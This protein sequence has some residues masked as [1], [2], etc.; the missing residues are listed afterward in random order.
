MAT[1]TQNQIA[2]PDDQLQTTNPLGV[3]GGLVNSPPSATVPPAPPAPTYT[4]TPTTATGYTATPYTVPNEAT[5]QERVKSIIGEDSALMQQ[6]ETRARQEAQ[7]RGLV[8]SSL[9]VGA[10][11]QAVI[12]QALPIAQQDAQTYANAATNTANQQNAAS[13]FNAGAQNTVGLANAQQQNA[14]LANNQQAAVQLTNTQMQREAQ[15]ALANLDTQTR[16]ALSTMDTQ[17]RQ[18]LQTNQSASNAY[19]QAVTNISNITNSNTMS[20]EAKDRAV[21]TQLNLLNEQL[22]TIGTLASTSPAEISELN[23]GSF[24]QASVETAGNAPTGTSPNVPS[25]SPGNLPPTPSAPTSVT[26]QGTPYWIGANGQTFFN[27]LA[28]QESLSG[29]SLPGY[30]GGQLQPSGYV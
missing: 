1:T 12:A 6:A 15:I 24:F 21:Q 13:Q 2:P 23:L 22:R 7:A 5:V 11:Q 25:V 19:V 28:A 30:I 14:A 17:T 26:P 18:L 16:L 3:N 27:E 9:A 10:G 8:N 4:T 29:F 20:Q